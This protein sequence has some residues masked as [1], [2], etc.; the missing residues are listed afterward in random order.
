M[1]FTNTFS[2]R[3]D[4][5][6]VYRT[7][8]DIERVTPCVPGAKVLEQ[9]DERSFKASV[10][11]RVGP[12]AMQY[13]SDVEIVSRDDDDH[14]AVLAVKAREVRGQGTAD[15]T[16]EMRVQPLGDAA[17]VAVAT[18]VRLTGK[19]AAM[20]HGIIQS[21]SEQLVDQFARNLATMLEGGPDAQPPP[22]GGEPV[23]SSPSHAADDALDA[24]GVV[25]AVVT[26]RL[27]DPR[28]LAGI[29]VVLA[30]LLWVW[31]IARR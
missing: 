3:A 30:L 17:E 20:G 18:E 27:R 2:I 22:A 29:A 23:P 24:G 25:A 13:R 8:L 11:V 26:S 14:H 16:A 9:I 6:D 31:R 12:V 28:T 1:D 5:D 19:V 7:L 10:K 15:A 4:V 21:V